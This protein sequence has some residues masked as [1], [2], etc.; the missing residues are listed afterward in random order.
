MAVIQ[1]N[2]R[3]CIFC[4]DRGVNSKEHFFPD[5]LPTAVKEWETVS[6]HII[7]ATEDLNQETKAKISKATNGPLVTRKI[8]HGDTRNPNNAGCS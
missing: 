3:L 1:K 4:A 8:R 5:W 2:Q 7:R 6:H